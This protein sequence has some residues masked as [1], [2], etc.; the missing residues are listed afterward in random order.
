MSWLSK[1]SEILFNP[2]TKSDIYDLQK[3]VGLNVPVWSQE[4]LFE[5]LNTVADF[6]VIF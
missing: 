1:F 5:S 6:K 4:K 2:N 3:S